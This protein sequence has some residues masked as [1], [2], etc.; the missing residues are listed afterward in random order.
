MGERSLFCADSCVPGVAFVMVKT[1]C[2][3]FGFLRWIVP[4][5]KKRAKDTMRYNVIRIIKTRVIGVEKFFFV[6]EGQ[7]T[8]NFI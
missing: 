2:C 3:C 7:R 4:R 6:L 5:C 1:R 8:R